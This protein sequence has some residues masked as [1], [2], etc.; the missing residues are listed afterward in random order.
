[1]ETHWLM[2]L[3][4]R[5]NHDVWCGV[6]EEWDP[7]NIIGLQH[8]R[9]QFIVPLVYKMQGRWHS[10]C[11]DIILQAGSP[12]QGVQLEQ[13][14][15]SSVND[16]YPKEDTL[17]ESGYWSKTKLKIETQGK[18]LPN[19]AKAGFESHVLTVF[20]ILSSSNLQ[21]RGSVLWNQLVST[22]I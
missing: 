22:G 10:F 5:S 7:H 4:F 18:K 12:E 15:G 8:L 21:F 11:N 2:P 3:R 13:S 9:A 19:H 14:T 6:H 1:M 20:V 16:V 17:R